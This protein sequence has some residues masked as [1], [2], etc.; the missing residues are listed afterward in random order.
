MKGEVTPGRVLI[1]A[2]Q[3]DGG[4]GTYV[5]QLAKLPQLQPNLVVSVLVLEKPHFRKKTKL[6][7]FF[8]YSQSSTS[9]SYKYKLSIRTI[10]DLISETIWLHKNIKKLQINSIISI[11]THCNIIA[12]FI[13]VFFF[14]NII[15]IATT[16]N[17]LHAVTTHKLTPISK[18]LIKLFGHFLLSHAD[19]LIGVSKGVSKS[20]KDFFNLKR[21]VNTIYNG[22]NLSSNK[23]KKINGLHKTH[24]LT[25]ISMGRFTKQK[26][27]QT[28]ILAFAQVH[29]KMPRT[30]LLLLGNGE[31]KIKLIS[32]VK[33][34]QLTKAV[35][36]KG[37]LINANTYLNRA[38][39][40]VL[41]SHYEGFPYVLLEAMAHHLPIIATDTKYGPREILGNNKFGLLVPIGNVEIMAK[42]ILVLLNNSASR[43]YYSQQAFKRVLNFSE[44]KMLRQYL[45]FIN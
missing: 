36:F 1:F 17:N 44:E 26:D 11:D 42:Q 35:L 19:F 32:L 22:I 39:L 3:I 4:T 6:R 41:S 34:L 28:L 16:H 29:I 45:K 25:I 40:F 24:S 15:L 31:E 2:K 9:L 23:F 7:P 12:A 21:E 14:P 8:F 38:S 5:Q 37:W 13:K 10:T 20:V 18:L 30:K 43:E 33:K 27:F